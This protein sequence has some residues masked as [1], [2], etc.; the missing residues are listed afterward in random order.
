MEK[1][2]PFFSTSGIVGGL[3]HPNDGHV[4]PAS[5]THALAKGARRRISGGAACCEGVR[6][7]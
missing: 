4:D 2:F 6:N 3:F 1:I 5:V 7:G